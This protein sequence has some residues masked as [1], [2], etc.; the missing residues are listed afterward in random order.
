[1]ESGHGKRV[2]VAFGEGLGERKHQLTK[3]IT[4][5]TFVTDIVNH[6]EAEELDDLILVGDSLAAPSSPARPTGSPSASATW[7]ISTAP[8]W[9]T[10]GACSAP[11]RRISWPRAGSWSPRRAKEGKWCRS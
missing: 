10:A 9:R 11:C 7:S 2:R 6:I 1:M 5:E 4:I 3:D 8:S